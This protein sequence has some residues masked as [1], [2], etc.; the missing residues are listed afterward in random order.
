MPP[1]GADGPPLTPTPPALEHSPATAATAEGSVS[2]ASRDEAPRAT[3]ASSWGHYELLGLLGRGGM[4][5][6]HRA[7]DTRLGRQ[8]AL[9]FIQ[10]AAP[11]RAM[12][13]VQE[14][15]AQARIDHP[16]VCKVFEVGE[17]DGRTF[18]AMQ[19]VEGELLEHAA[20][21]M[22]LTR[23]LRLMKHVAEAVHA[24]HALGVIHRDLKP[25]NIMVRGADSDRPTPVILD[26]GLAYELALGHG[27]TTTGA[28]LG[29]PAYMAPEQ[30]RGEVR[31]VDHRAD[32][33]AL[34]AT[35]YELLTGAPPFQGATPLETLAK[36]LD[37]EFVP[38]RARVPTL[39]A[40]LDTVCL[41]CLAREPDQRYGSSLALA[42]DLG[43]ILDGQ[44]I[45]GRG[46]GLVDRVRRLARAHRV[47]FWLS[48]GSLSGMLLLGA[49]GGQAWLSRRELEARTAS[50]VLLAEQ[51][52]QQVRELESFVR[53]FQALPLH[54]TRP[55]LRLARERLAKLSA[56][57]PGLGPQEEGLVRQAL[58]RGHLALREFE[59]AHEALERAHALGV[60]T[61]G[62]HYAL[63]RAL[64]ERYRQGLEDARREG[65]ARWV[66]E[67]RRQLEA[68][69]LTPALAS[70]E[71]SRSLELESPRY[72]EGLIALYRGEHE[73]AEHAAQEA[74]AQASWMPEARA[75]A[76][77]V[78]RARAMMLL[79]QG[80]YV[81]ARRWLEEAG[82]RYE[83]TLELGR[84]DAWGHAAL[85]EVWL[86]RS[87]L[88]KREGRSRKAALDEAERAVER[89]LTAD[90]ERA[91]GH[92]QRAQVLMNQYR[93][94]NFQGEPDSRGAAAL[95][96]EWTRA[97]ARAV[98]LDP[99]DV[100]ALDSLGYSHFMRG[101]RQ[102]R[103]GEAPEASWSEALRWLSRALEL[104]PLYPWAL[105]DLG[106]VHRWRGNHLREHGGDPL[107]AYEQAARAF[108]DATRVDPQYLF[109]HSNLA[110]LYVAMAG[111]RLGLGQDPE[112][113]VRRALEASGRARAIDARFHS[114]LEH[115][116]AAE[117]TRARHLE[118]TE[119]DPGPA[120]ERALSAALEAQRLN[121]RSERALLHQATVHVERARWMLREGS[122]A[123]AALRDTRSE[124]A[125]R[126]Q[127]TRREA[128]DATATLDANSE[129]AIPLQTSVYKAQA[130]KMR[131]ES[132]DATATLDANSERAIPLQTPLQEG[133]A[134]KTL[135]EAGDTTAA[136]E[137]QRLDTRSESAFTLPR[138]V[139]EEHARWTL[140]EG[141][142][143]AALEAG[144]RALEEAYRLSPSCADC[145]VM[146]AWLEL[147]AADLEQLRGGSGLP[148]LRRALDEARRAVALY[149]YDESHLMMAR[150]C[151]RWARAASPSVSHEVEEEGL[152]HVEKA[153]R[154]SPGLAE[155]EALRAGLLWAR[156]RGLSDTASRE[157]TLGEAR[158]VLDQVLERAPR[159][160]RAYPRL[161]QD[162]AEPAH[163]GAALRA[164]PAAP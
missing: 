88:D 137:T 162:L 19:L 12:R 141:E 91:A 75:L 82:Q 76:G 105:N 89:S 58:G 10:G 17:V 44:P 79:E 86:Q 69:F 65:G 146:G 1:H 163:T 27:L 149:A 161:V 96:E 34:G 160:S 52:G 116:A 68:R 26:F 83:K 121:A 153:L 111:H 130:P 87:E 28:V 102:A 64:G 4:G 113:D 51:L 80:D 22:T 155:A 16:H 142:A 138:T 35:L 77:D 3:A 132:G 25:S 103:A 158:T 134:A 38:P 45:L 104:Q 112:D 55:E 7:R 5:E 61:P 151:W 128:G 49:V 74:M 59:Q 164:R 114:A 21:R 85:A 60:D 157:A 131:H 63:G 31:A 46:P 23:K 107:P 30:A 143:T 94:V 139:Q 98:E 97:A 2:G 20:A 66:A 126:T 122:D 24:A 67:Q 93:A 120:L 37:G 14:A 119:Q 147:T 125:P 42:E 133:Q 41:K 150:A 47:A 8:V 54:D 43:R 57:E 152:S 100:L 70:L 145:R 72:L 144:R 92:T 32:I 90:P 123:T 156:A 115:T 11:E 154:L 9:K 117:L 101:L 71:R 95:L 78:A 53:A 50:R 56:M 39:E 48:A 84:S 118:Q 108:L 62:L 6:V 140:R 81:Q 15:R 73:A 124:H 36:V 109:A 136:L 106:L 148:R 127:K 13:L 159:L 29:T 135:R 40:A 110:E 18:I 99:R 129:R 33:Y